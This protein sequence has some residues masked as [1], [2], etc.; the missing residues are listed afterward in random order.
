MKTPRSE[1]ALQEMHSGWFLVPLAWAL[2]ALAAV[3]VLGFAD[4]PTA[5]IVPLAEPAA[6]PEPPL[7]AT[8]PD[9]NP[10]AEAADDVQAF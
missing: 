10:A 5:E 9:V 4:E 2:A 7:Q 6:L 8:L 3:L 1:E